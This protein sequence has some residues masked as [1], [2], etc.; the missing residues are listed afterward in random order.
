MKRNAPSTKGQLDKHQKNLDRP[1]A[2]FRTGIIHNRLA[3]LTVTTALSQSQSYALISWDQRSPISS[4]FSKAKMARSFSSI[5]TRPKQQRT[6]QCLMIIVYT[7]VSWKAT[8]AMTTIDKP[9]QMLK[10]NSR[11]WCNRGSKKK[12]LKHQDKRTS[13][14]SRRKSDWRKKLKIRTSILIC[15]LR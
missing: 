5:R 14:M 3:L 4:T 6:M 7:F 10:L 8:T 2:L 12:T 11:Q 9:K 15:K 1:S 13:K